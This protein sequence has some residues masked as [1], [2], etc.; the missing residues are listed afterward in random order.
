MINETSRTIRDGQAYQLDVC[1]IRAERTSIRGSGAFNEKVRDIA[2]TGLSLRSTSKRTV[3]ALSGPRTICSIFCKI[4]SQPD[5]QDKKVSKGA[6][7]IDQQSCQKGNGGI[8]S[9]RRRWLKKSD[10]LKQPTVMI[11]C[12]NKS[13]PRRTLFLSPLIRNPSPPIHLTMN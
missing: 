2:G 10:K 7:A 12:A 11:G 4:S 8:F 13:S 1:F 3:W 5:C 6:G 9:Q